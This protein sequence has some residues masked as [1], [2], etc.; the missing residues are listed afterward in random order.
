MPNQSTNEARG[1]KLKRTI[2]EQIGAQLSLQVKLVKFK[3]A[4]RI[5]KRE[6][7]H[8]WHFPNSFLQ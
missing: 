6:P 8:V 7:K 2:N 3:V 1:A 5:K 4:S